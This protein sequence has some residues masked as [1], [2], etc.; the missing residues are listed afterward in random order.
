MIK[1]ISPNEA[2]EKVNAGAILV[3]VRELDEINE[4]GYGID[5]QK[6]IP[7]SEFG[8]RFNELD[9]N[10]DIILACKSGGRSMNAAMFLVENGYTTLSNLD[11]G[12]MRWNAE[13]FPVQ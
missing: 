3:D 4:L 2:I 8:Q 9:K 10:A 5:N 6:I 1:N 11:G 12:I 13:G 7:L